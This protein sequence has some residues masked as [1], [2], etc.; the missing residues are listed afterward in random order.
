MREMKA[1]IKTAPGP[2]SDMARELKDRYLAPMSSGKQLAI[3]EPSHDATLAEVREVWLPRP[4]DAGVLAAG[5]GAGL[6]TNDMRGAV[7]SS[8]IAACNAVAAQWLT[9]R[10][11][12]VGS[13]DQIVSFIDVDRVGVRF[14]MIIGRATGRAGAYRQDAW[15]WSARWA[16]WADVLMGLI[17]ANATPAH[18]AGVESG[19]VIDLDSRRV[20]MALG[21][22]NARDE[23]G[24]E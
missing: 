19:D 2:I 3:A 9:A 18:R 11:L 5:C 23:W 12:D 14:T 7:E 16:Y 10:G 1:Q 20:A 4:D 22:H 21:I 24:D 15:C 13:D 8:M 6:V 17:R